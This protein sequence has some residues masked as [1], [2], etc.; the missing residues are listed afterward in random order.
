[1]EDSDG[2]QDGGDCRT[3]GPEKALLTSELR[4]ELQKN[5]PGQEEEV[6]VPGGSKSHNTRKSWSCW[7][8][9]GLEHGGWGG[10]GTRQ[11][12]A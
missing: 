10:G 11:A 12:G 9:Q 8:I 7:R 6:S 2:G 1:M 5:P 3:Q 4:W